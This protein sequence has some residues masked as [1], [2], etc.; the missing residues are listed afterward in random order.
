MPTGSPTLSF[1]TTNENLPAVLDVLRY[2]AEIRRE[3]ACRFWTT[4]QDSIQQSKPAALAAQLS[5]EQDFGKDQAKRFAGLTK[6]EDMK[7]A[8]DGCL[9]GA[10]PQ[11]AQGLRYRI[12]ADPEC[13]GAGLAWLKWDAR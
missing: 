6:A 8:L 10:R 9:P 13:L 3:L 4:F 2:G 12:E 7:F 1:L 11:E 5:W